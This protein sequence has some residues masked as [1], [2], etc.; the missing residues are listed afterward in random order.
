M[1]PSS[2]KPI[3]PYAAAATVDL[4]N[5]DEMATVRHL[6]ASSARKL[7]AGMLSELEIEAF[8]EY[9][10]SDA[11]AARIAQTVQAG[12]LV[13][14]RLSNMLVATAGWIP[15]NDSGNVARLVG[16]FVSPLFAGKGIGRLVVERIEA[17]ARL[18]GFQTFAIRAP[19]GASGF[20]EHLGYSAASHGVWPLTRE[21]ALP[22]A[23]LRKSEARLVRPQP[24]E[25][26]DD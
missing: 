10:Y 20:F 3:S 6:H 14:A 2:P 7:A 15:A 17:Q 26:D 11:Y 18:G 1:T 22:V 23:F 4:V 13:A 16:V 12:R 21:T 8:A 24:P 19:L 9:V 25:G 5:I